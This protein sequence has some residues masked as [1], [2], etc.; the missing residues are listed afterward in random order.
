[1]LVSWRWLSEF[2]NTEGVDPLAFAG[3]FTCAVAEIDKVH[4]TGMGLE[5]VVVADVLEVVPHPNADKLRLAT[6]DVGL[7]APVTVVCGAPD[8]AVGQ[9][10][11]FVPP[12]VTLPSGI[13]VRDGEVRGVRSP[14]ML[15]S[16][17]DLGLS[18]EHGGLLHL[19]GCTVPAG[20]PL[21]EAVD[22]EDV[23][24][25]VDNKSITHRPDLWGQYG[26]ARE[27]AALLDRPLRPLALDL[28]L[29]DAHL[30]E[31]PPPVDLAVEAPHLCPRYLCARVEGVTVG[32][33]PVA[34]RLR[35][36]R[37]GV[38][39][40]GN[41][42]DA[43]NLVMLETGN[44]LHAFDARSLRG[45]AIR[46]RT[47]RPGEVLRTLDDQ[48]RALLPTDC[49]IADGEG[50]VALAGIMGGGDSEI[51]P[52]TQTV[53][54]EAAAFDAPA[55]RKTAL[56]LGLRTESSA[57]FEKSL[58]PA[59]PDIAAR[60][61]LRLLLQLSPGAQ[62]VSR[63]AD[64]GPF[65]KAPPPVVQVATTGTYLRQRL[66]VD[67][68]EMP[69][70]W[71]DKCLTALEF[72]VHRVA[73][74]LTVT[75]PTFRATRDVR[76]Q[77]DLVEELGRHYGY[78]RIRSVAPLVPA[79]PPYTPPLRLLE[80]QVRQVLVRAAGLT[81]VLLYGFEHEAARERLGLRER[82]AA[83]DTDLPRQPDLPRPPDLPRL[84]VRNAIS[85]EH[86]NL[87]RN[88]APNLLVAVESNLLQGDGRQASK[89]GLQIGLF[90]IGRAYVPVPPDVERKG[91]DLGIPA[92]LHG[93]DPQA[94]ARYLG[95]MDAEM[96]AGV[97]AAARGATPLPW[98]PMRL[99]L[100]LGERLG[101]GAEG[102]KAAQPPADV[103]QRLF[104]AVVG[105]VQ[106]VAAAAG[107][108]AL[109]VRRLAV[110]EDVV[111][112]TPAPSDL[113]ATWIHPQRHAI[114]RGKD[115]RAVGVVTALHPAV[116]QQLDVPAEVV[117]AELDLEALLA[118]PER[119]V[120]GLAPALH[121]ASAVDVTLRAPRN[122]RVGEVRAA[123]QAAT[124]QAAPAVEA[125]EFLYEH[126]EGDVRALTFRLTC[127]LVERTVTA[128]DVAA[129]TAAVQVAAG[130]LMLQV[131]GA[132][133]GRNLA[134][135][136]R[137]T[138]EP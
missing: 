27:V 3:R 77:D 101:G 126:G 52:D 20:T 97:E 5:A 47:A 73:D 2:V 26:M 125:V 35:L 109:E 45:N 123:L 116:R 91:L 39:P 90:E 118:Q 46:V 74:A 128:E 17:A 85:S 15:A 117:L 64:A 18:E 121:P 98:Q 59:L 83:G 106:A 88:L 7:G 100:A 41:V 1:M 81:E 49:V 61:F 58:D 67:T 12:G 130:R 69:D 33:S 104:Q 135:T 63:L 137:N 23:L 108:D 103:T 6:C 22:I 99:G 36:R 13:T 89:K 48:E 14:G 56:R 68:A 8:L 133:A 129:A 94:L 112:A 87:R 102:S 70:A 110:G 115:G 37:L 25:E 65:Q 82:T 138:S 107:I 66:G 127:R 24:Y 124:T 4:R 32:P 71:M 30:A 78:Q 54:L 80:R 96:R 16:E 76:H 84:G 122:A 134:D 40:I 105:A 111:W 51:R 57:R 55:I 92:V 113:S 31:L 9:R 29:S 86:G 42:V 120:R 10:V 21:P 136:G 28:P 50:P 93:D 62:I 114:L 132:D 19:D 79:R 60:R 95:G 44:P 75:V 53:V 38:R 72:G 34:L 43:T 119:Q 11:P 131:A